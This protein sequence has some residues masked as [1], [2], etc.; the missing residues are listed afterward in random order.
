MKNKKIKFFFMFCCISLIMVSIGCKKDVGNKTNGSKNINIICEDTV[1]PMVSDLVHDYNSNNETTITVKSEDRESAFNKLY[2]SETDVLIGYIQPISDKIKAEML[3]YDG[4][5]IIV[6]PSNNVNGISIQE[7]KKIYIGKIANW[8][9]LNGQSNPI[10]PVAFKDKFNSIQ[11]EFNLKI[12][13]TPIKEEMGKS[14]Q[15]VSSMEEMKT[16]IAQNKNSIGFLPGQWYNKESKFLKLSGV[17]ITISNLKNNLYFLRFP[18]KMYYSE[19]KEESLKDLFQYFKSED[20]KKIIRK[21]C[22]E[23]F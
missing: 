9:G 22:I 19:K 6:N 14:T 4:I 7:L 17:E 5:G 3:A 1:F 18:I 2:N 12:K 13:D 15:Y 21:Y 10:I 8:E 20:G 11:Q 23:A 16:F